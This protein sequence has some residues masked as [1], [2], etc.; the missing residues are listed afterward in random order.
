MFKTFDKGLSNDELTGRWT[1][2]HSS[3]LVVPLDRKYADKDLVVVFD[4]QTLLSKNFPTQSLTCYLGK[5][6]LAVI[7]YQYPEFQK[8]LE[9]SIPKKLHGGKDLKFV[10]ETE[11]LRSPAQMYTGN[12]DKRLLGVNLSSC[13]ISTPLLPKWSRK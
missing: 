3:S 4:T 13:R 8:K 10:F 7:K 5:E 1:L 9:I 12:P 2:A 6:K 11:H